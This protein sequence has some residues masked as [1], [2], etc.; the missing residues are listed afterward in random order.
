M[1]ASRWLEDLGHV[2]QHRIDALVRRVGL[3]DLPAAVGHGP[4]QCGA[5]QAALSGV[6]SGLLAISRSATSARLA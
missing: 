5:S 3:Q 4:D 1:Q 6:S 2:V